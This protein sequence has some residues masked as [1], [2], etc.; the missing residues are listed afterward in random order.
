MLK[1]EFQKIKRQKFVFYTLV[2]ACLFPIPL[3]VLILHTKL[4]YD[5]LFMFV[6][7][8]GFFL[9]LPIVL[10][11]VATILFRME[12]EN[13][14]LKMLTIIPVSRGR[15][16]VAKI[17]VL[18]ILAIFYGIMA[19]VSTIIGGLLVGSVIGIISKIIISLGLSVL[20]V[21]AVLPIV[22]IVV[23][24]HRNIILPILC[25]VVYAISS[26]VF[27]LT[28]SRFPSPLTLVF[29]LC[30]PLIS[31]TPERLATEVGVQEWIMP[32][33][34]CVVILIGIGIVCIILS[35]EIYRKQEV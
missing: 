15:M 17:M 24:F 32:F 2:A 21:I 5:T 14:T 1:I 25:A 6:M 34:P 27:S 12:N 9:V 23:A 18:L 28:M 13:G 7:E 22:A 10:G 8:F 11:T 3:T 20:I 29:R 30:L 31:A 4:S 33:F 16:V 35:V 19:T 26:F